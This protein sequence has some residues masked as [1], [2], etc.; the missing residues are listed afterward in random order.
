MCSACQIAHYKQVWRIAF[1]GRLEERK[2]IKLFVE[3]VN[4]LQDDYDIM[5]LE[6]FE[7]YIV[8]PD[9]IVDMV[10]PHRLP[11]PVLQA[12]TLC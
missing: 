11:V 6:A 1:F 5:D 10:T 3:A 12:L 4:K 7:I 9:A 2:G 8:G